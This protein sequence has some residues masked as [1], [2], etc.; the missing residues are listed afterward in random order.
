MMGYRCLIFFAI[1]IRL[2]FLEIRITA[3]TSVLD[4]PHD[5]S[6]V[7]AFVNLKLVFEEFKCHSNIIF[8]FDNLAKIVSEYCPKQPA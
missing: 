3:F 4:V 8:H 2:S 5:F 7:F 6:L 1:R